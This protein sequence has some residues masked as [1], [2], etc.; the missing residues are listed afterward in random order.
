V[1]LRLGTDTDLTATLLIALLLAWLATLFESIAW[2]G[3]ETSC[4]AGRFCCSILNLIL[5]V[6]I[7]VARFGSR[8]VDGSGCC[9][10][11]RTTLA[12]SAVAGAFL[13]RLH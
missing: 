1:P 12:G 2:K 7:L 13:G 8:P 11:S 5:T 4:A 3:L 9:V 10:P 6:A